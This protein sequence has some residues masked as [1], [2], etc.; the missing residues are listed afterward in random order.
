[1]RESFA[2]ISD[3]MEHLQGAQVVIKN[4]FCFELS[5][6]G[7]SSTFTQD[8]LVLMITNR[9]ITHLQLVLW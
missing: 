4:G 1:M 9:D 2:W 8:K 3:L 5:S 6:L 7:C